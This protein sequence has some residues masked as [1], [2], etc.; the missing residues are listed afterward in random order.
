MKELEYEE[1]SFWKLRNI[2]LKLFLLTL[3]IRMKKK[4]LEKYIFFNV[5]MN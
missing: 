5:V 4:L 3:F 1:Q 2:F